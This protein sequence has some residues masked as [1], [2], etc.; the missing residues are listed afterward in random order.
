MCRD[1]EVAGGASSHGNDKL[2]RRGGSMRQRGVDR[3]GEARH[4]HGRGKE[5]G[6]LSGRTGAKN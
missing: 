1:D 6:L 5:I 2:R 3:Q 4:S